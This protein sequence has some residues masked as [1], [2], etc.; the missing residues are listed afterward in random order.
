MWTAEECELLEFCYEDTPSAELARL[1]DRP[2]HQVYG[3][4][5]K[6][7]LSK[8][9][10]FLASPASGILRKG[11]TRPGSEVNWF[12]KGH[13]P[14]NKGLRRPGYAPGRMASTQFKKG[15]RERIP[16]GGRRVDRD[17]YVYRRISDTGY[18]G[19]DWRFEHVLVWVEAHGPVPT[20]HVIAFK[21]RNRGNVALDNLECILRAELMRRNTIHNLPPELVDVIRLSGKIKQVLRRREREE[22]DVRPAQPPVRNARS[23]EG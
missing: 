4:A 21:D 1:L 9:A 3:K 8:S 22:Q 15:R 18:G 23:V 12:P 2:L 7:G 14:S 16:I 20:G 19:T 6:M 10:E 13:V 17:G 5:A 11:E